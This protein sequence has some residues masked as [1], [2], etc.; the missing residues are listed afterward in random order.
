MAKKKPPGGPPPDSDP[1]YA[2]IARAWE[3]WLQHK[4]KGSY[5]TVKEDSEMAS[6]GRGGK[7]QYGTARG[8][9]AAPVGGVQTSETIA[10]RWRQLVIGQE[11]FIS[12]VEPFLAMHQ[13]GLSDPSRPIGAFLL[14]GP[15]GTG[16][17]KSVQAL[18]AAI[19]GS[20][21]AMVRIDCA[22]YQME[23][24]V[25]KLIGAPPGYLGHR[26]TQPVLSQSKLV[27]SGSDKSPVI[28]LLF[29]EVEKAAESLKR[30]LLGILDSA[31]LRLGDGV[32]VDFKNCLIFFTS[33]LGSREIETRQKGFG[34]DRALVG[35]SGAVSAKEM[36]QIANA[37]INKRMSPEFRNRLSATVHYRHLERAEVEQIAILELN[38]LQTRVAVATSTVCRYSPRVIQFLVDRGYSRAYG[39]RELKRTI[40]REFTVPLSR[41]ITSIKPTKE[42]SVIVADVEE[43]PDGEPAI[44]YEVVSATDLLDD[45]VQRKVA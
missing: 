36:R 10:E 8:P 19:H 41:F 17:T 5:Y 44:G 13:A 24:E 14:A 45:D 33:N 31:S 28:V 15:T 2:T 35:S 12:T 9:V 25:A 29:D 21:K 16:K 26:E 18:A 39:A 37:V 7:A 38:E 22:E 43:T 20:V 6:V 4:E 32:S 42:F 34:L 40:E 1:Y 11:E 27:N 30:M 23:H 3:L